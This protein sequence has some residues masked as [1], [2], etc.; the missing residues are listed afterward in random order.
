MLYNQTMWAYEKTIYQIYTIGFCGA[1][2]RNDG[3]KAD[4]L[5][6]V[7]DYIP[8]LKRLG[9]GAVLFN[10]LFESESHGYDTRD[11]RNVDVRLGTN[12][13]LAELVK[14]LHDS[15]IRVLLDAV[16]NHVGR[17]FFAFEDVR[18]NRQ[19]SRYCSWFN[20]SFDGNSWFNDGFWY[21]DW[22]GCSDL[23][24][25][26]LANPEVREYLLES[27]RLWIQEFD[28][29]GLRL[30]VAYL[31]N[32][33]FIRE[34]RARTNSLKR[35]FFLVGEALFGD[36]NPLI[37]EGMLDSVTNYE[38]YKGIYSSINSGNFFEISYSYNR[39]FGN[40][41][42]CL[43]TGR[44]LL[45]FADNHD[46]SRIASLLS[47][48]RNL[49]IAYGLIFSMPGIPCLYYGS[50]WG[51][52]GRKEDGDDALRPCVAA[53]EWNTLTE[54]ICRLIRIRNEEKALSYG[55]YRNVQVTNHQ[56]V[57][58]RTWNE[59]QVFA[60][61]NLADEDFTV[62]GDY[63]GNGMR[64]LLE[65]EDFVPEGNI[66]I[67]AHKVKLLKTQVQEEGSRA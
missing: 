67:P 19:S 65:N 55:N 35:D 44:H 28:I 66:V 8:H 11:M 2:R 58:E 63:L 25:L 7:E 61:F 18:K 6:K 24:K 27:V 31:L 34:L 50:E 59:E 21:E 22:E 46:V 40:D 52:R 43:Y 14:R 51:M 45:S 3:I 56:L 29:D 16:F 41:P 12:K 54:F 57:F 1:P 9:I 53:P 48:E 64:D 42:W 62:Y 10:P 4:R 33:D 36:Y 47:D 32:H 20:L 49:E 37:A 30:D 23:V 15:G 60:F 17:S 13:D 5:K 26:N 38:C 39:Q